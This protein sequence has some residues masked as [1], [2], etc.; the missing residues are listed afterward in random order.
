MPHRFPPL[1]QPFNCHIN[2]SHPNGNGIH[3]LTNRWQTDILDLRPDYVF[4]LIGIN[5]VWRWFDSN[6][7]HN[8]ALST[9]ESYYQEYKHLI[10]E[11]LPQTKNIFVLSP[12]M[13]ELNSKDLMRKK[14]QKYQV[15]AKKV[16]HQNNLQY[17]DI[18][19]AID[20]FLKSQSPYIVTKDRV[21]PNFS[22]H[23]FVANIIL[24]SIGFDPQRLIKN[25]LVQN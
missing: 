23:M 17:I 3:Q 18:Q 11:T 16:A 9:P 8:I 19:V 5:D 14:L 24:N 2:P 15:L 12:F 10:E 1:L 22:G 25:T 6:F 20:R 13:F 4:I 7:Q 21:H